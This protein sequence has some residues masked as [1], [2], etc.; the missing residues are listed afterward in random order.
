MKVN[1]VEKRSGK[2]N[3]SAQT[4]SATHTD[5]LTFSNHFAK[6]ANTLAEPVTNKVLFII[7]VMFIHSH[8][9]KGRY[10]NS[11]CRDAGMV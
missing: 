8:I 6:L 11:L 1:F 2:T 3:E 5:T 7:H 10:L 9:L 4:K